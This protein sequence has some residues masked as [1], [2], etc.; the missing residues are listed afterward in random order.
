MM[1]RR[2]GKKRDITALTV[3]DL[4]LHVVPCFELYHTKR[5]V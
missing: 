4:A 1:E 5:N 2:D 3:Y